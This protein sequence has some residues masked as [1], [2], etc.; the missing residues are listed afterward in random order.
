MKKWEYRIVTS[1]DLQAG[2]F[3]IVDRDAIVKHLNELGGDGWEMVSMEFIGDTAARLDF[4]ALMKR[5]HP[6]L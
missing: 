3:N 5:E 6:G 4:R 1:D 2:F